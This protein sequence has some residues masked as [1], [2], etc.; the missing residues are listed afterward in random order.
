MVQQPLV[1]QT[2]RVTAVET[3]PQGGLVVSWTGNT[4]SVVNAADFARSGGTFVVDGDPGTVYSFTDVVEGLD[5]LDPDVVTTVEPAP[6]G[7]TGERVNIW[8]LASDTYA[9][10]ELPDAADAVHA[11]VTHALKAFLPDGVREPEAREWVNIELRG[12][13]WFVAEVV[14]RQPSITSATIDGL[15][16]SLADL[17][18][19]L[20]QLDVAMGEARTGLDTLDAALTQAQADLASLD[21]ALE[22]GNEALAHRITASLATFQTIYANAITANMLNVDNALAQK[23]QAVIATFQ[24]VFAGTITADMVDLDTLN[25]K[26]LNGVDIYSPN[27]TAVPRVHVGGSAIEVVRG[28]GETNWTSVALGGDASDRMQLLTPEG[29]VLAGFDE[30]GSATATEL[31]VSG[32]TTLAGNVDIGSLSVGG[33]TLQEWLDQQAK[34]VVAR[35]ELGTGASPNNYEFG[36]TTLGLVELRFTAEA[37][38]AYKIVY[39]GLAYITQGS[40][41]FAFRREVAAGATT[42]AEPK[43]STSPQIASTVVQNFQASQSSVGLHLETIVNGPASAGAQ[44]SY[45]VMLTGMHLLSTG[46]G[47]LTT[48]DD[49]KGQFYVEDLGPNVATDDG[50]YMWG[51]GTPY[52]G[53]T[54]PVSQPPAPRLVVKTYTSVWHSTW[55]RVWRGG[56]VV[57]DGTLHQGLYGG[58]Q[59]QTMIGFPSAN[60]AAA[61]A[62]GKVTKVEVY[63][64]NRSWYASS[65]GIARIGVHGSA[66]APASFTGAGST[67]DVSGWKTGTGRWVTLPSGW[68]PAFGVGGNKGITLG[69]GDPT[70]STYYG[71]FSADMADARIRVTYQK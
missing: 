52:T 58:V 56:S 18:D 36:N 62:G 26:T 55:N 68:W 14:G 6:A 38:R 37:G 67:V 50:R 7:F 30:T 8:P 46:H 49:Y 39:D 40:A 60:I 41:I 3:E 12:S 44:T 32:D 33:I 25:G 23:L 5:E 2:G 42:P 20:G 69:E 47:R 28:D 71:K 31:S 65:G 1:W 53:A 48:R 34:G 51:G 16:E 43:V 59:R 15:D 45:R 64:V 9:M 61:V 24:E 11:T 63:L 10:V 66:S 19:A 21:E 29:E 27:Q 22:P 35:Q 54:A 13:E 57:S 17:A 70:S 4:L